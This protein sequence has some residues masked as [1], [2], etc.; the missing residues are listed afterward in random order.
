M[1]L[2]RAFTLVELLVVIGIIALLV[3]ILLPALNKA[4]QQAQRLACASNLRSQ[5]QALQIYVGDTRHYPGHVA[6]S[7][8]GRQIA[9]WPARLRKY[10]RAGRGIFWCPANEPGF[11]WQ[12]VSGAGAQYATAADERW[13]YDL[14]ELLLDVHVVPFSYGYNDWGSYNVVLPQRG[15]GADLWNPA[16]PELRATK[17]RKPT[18]MIAIADN[19]S[20]GSWDYNLDP[21]N[22]REY[23]GQIHNKGANVLFCDGHVTWYSQAD[24]TRLGNATITRMWN[25]DNKP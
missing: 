12:T 9:V 21:R 15:L 18:E 23:P 13:G 14:G 3:A 6:L 25:N 22:P 17:V 10:A 7:S 24:L 4:K 16:T 2:R 11:Q 8:S 20:D 1:R 19:T 5:G